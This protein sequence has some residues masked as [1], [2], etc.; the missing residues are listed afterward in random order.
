MPL[1]IAT[2]KPLRGSEGGR[3]PVLCGA[4]MPSRE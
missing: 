4:P 1:D 3:E 2:A